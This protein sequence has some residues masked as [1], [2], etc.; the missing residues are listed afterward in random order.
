MIIRKTAGI[1]AALSILFSAAV[2][3]CAES[4]SAGSGSTD[5][6]YSGLAQTSSGELKQEFYL[7][8]KSSAE[9][10][11]SDD[12]DIENYKGYYV[13]DSVDYTEFGLS[14]NEAKE[15]YFTMRNDIPLLF[16]L[17]P[18]VAVEGDKLLMLVPKAY[19]CGQIRAEHRA[20]IC[21]Y[22]E[23]CVEKLKK[24]PTSYEKAAAYEE[25]LVSSAEFAYDGNR[26][27]TDADAHSPVGVIVNGKGV[28]ES[29]ARTF[30]LVMNYIGKECL[31]VAGIGGKDAHA[32]NIMRL[33]DGNYYNYDCTW[34]DLKG[35][36]LYMA[37]GSEVFNADHSAYTPEGVGA[38]FQVGMP[39][40]AVKGFDYDGYIKQNY[41]KYDIDLDHKANVTDLVRV[42][43]HIKG[44]RLLS[45]RMA[46]RADINGD[47]MINVND[48]IKISS[49]IKG[50]R[51]GE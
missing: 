34:D 48:V 29:Y 16:F 47:G 44:F 38:K 8:L 51:S 49:F 13:F 24:L 7:R 22:L 40:T 50:I 28:C 39:Q 2:P 4:I 1:F 35:E 20:E 25:L 18:T 30:Q 11:Y 19:A 12:R 17:S 27:S 6:G 31:L 32:W 15:V 41:S 42:C 21:S 36:S 5:H 9:E 14:K 43:A 46:E 23:S 37:S 3:A 10:L 33:D 26:P 45:G